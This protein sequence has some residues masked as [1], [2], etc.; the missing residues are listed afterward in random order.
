M[1]VAC[2]AAHGISTRSTDEQVI[3]IAG[4]Q[5]VVIQSAI[6][7]I[8]P[9]TTVDHVV[10]DLAQ[11]CVR[12]V[13]TRNG[14]I[15]KPCFDVVVTR[16][17]IELIVARVSEQ[18]IIAGAA[19]DLVWPGSTGEHVVTRAAIQRRRARSRGEA[20]VPT[21][22]FDIHRNDHARIDRESVVAVAEVADD[23]RHAAV[24]L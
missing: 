5:R 2:S 12:T 9:R 8:I 6:E 18:P 11:Q 24:G 13:A 4:G 16:F 15:A 22:A 10:A 21:P 1:I 17:A 23:A 14:I 7:L 3:A 19:T 20:V